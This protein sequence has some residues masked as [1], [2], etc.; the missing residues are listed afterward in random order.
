[1]WQSQE[2]EKE[3]LFS[4]NQESWYFLIKMCVTKKF[5]ENV[6]YVSEDHVSFSLCASVTKQKL[7]GKIMS[8]KYLLMD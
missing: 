8:W 1:M 6:D 2:D 3:F 5:T 4:K 7:C